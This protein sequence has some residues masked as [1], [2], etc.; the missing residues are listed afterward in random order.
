MTQPVTFRTKETQELYDEYRQNPGPSATGC[1]ICDKPVIAEF[2][3]WK[4]VANSFPYDKIASLH[5]MIVP[6]RHAREDEVTFEE[7]N[8]LNSIKLNSLYKQYDYTIQAT[9]RVQSVPSHYHLHL[10]N[11]IHE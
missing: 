11:S 6:I 8:E 5:H 3:S 10:L 7:W 4:I 9:P 1:W 2:K